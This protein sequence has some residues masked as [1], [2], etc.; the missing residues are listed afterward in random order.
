M[1]VTTHYSQLK[2]LATELP[3]IENASLEFDRKTLT[4]TFQLRTGIPGSSYA[5]EIA[6]RLGLSPEVCRQ[7]S[8]LVGSS[9]KSLSNL[10]ASLET[11]LAVVKKDQTELSERLAKVKNLEEFYTVQSKKLKTEIEAEKEKAL[12]ETESFLDE[13]RK[14][15]E[16]LV[17]EIRKSGAEPDTVKQ[18]HHSLQSRQ[19]KVR[20]LHKKKQTKPF[21]PSS[22]ENGDMVEILTLSQQG[23][24]TEIIGKERAKV[25]VGNVLTTVDLRNLRKIDKVV[26]SRKLKPV[27]GASLNDTISPEIHLMGMTGEE[28]IEALDR[29]LDRA[30]LAG[31]SQVYVVHGKGT[32]ALR[33][34]LSGYLKERPDVASIRLGNW[35]EGG[36]GVTI[37]KLKV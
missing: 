26:E 22:F 20:S 16:K 15:I 1:L 37:V 27:P 19:K 18:F 24:I 6:E 25:K 32:G 14:E 7:A 35:N 28:A 33:R 36:A 34:I 3:E 23:E 5:V 17:A 8:K 30:I 9:E 10:I 11:E 4:P 12:A 2:T 29:Y 21:D 13:T 31:L